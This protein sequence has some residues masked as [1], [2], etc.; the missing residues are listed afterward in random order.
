MV[1][2]QAA[3]HS[4]PCQ[5]GLLNSYSLLVHDRQ[6]RGNPKHSGQAIKISA[7]ACGLASS[8]ALAL[9]S[10]RVDPRPSRWSSE[11]PEDPR[12]RRDAGHFRYFYRAVF[13]ALDANDGLAQW[14]RCRKD[15]LATKASSRP[16]DSYPRS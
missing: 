14:V 6:Y 12:R 16:T 9:R 11:V 7:I 2:N 15:P 3:N 5:A 8:R 13:T 1:N 4:I 10:A